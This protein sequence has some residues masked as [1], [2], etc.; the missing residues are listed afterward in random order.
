M[1]IEAAIEGQRMIQMIYNI[2]Y[3]SAKILKFYK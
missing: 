3:K 1:L 2:K